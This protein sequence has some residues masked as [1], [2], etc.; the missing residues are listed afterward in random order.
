MGEIA[1]NPV[2]TGATTN[3]YRYKLKESLSRCTSLLRLV[4]VDHGALHC[5]TRESRGSSAFAT[6]AKKNQSRLQDLS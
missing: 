6:V 2:V 5:A 4:G 1:C 3:A